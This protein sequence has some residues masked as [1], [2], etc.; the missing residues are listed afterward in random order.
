MEKK[1]YIFL[2]NISPKNILLILFIL[3]AVYYFHLFWPQLNVLVTPDFGSSDIWH[4]HMPLK[5]FLAE[6]L[7]N[8]SFPF[9][10][11]DLGTGYPLLAQGH[12]G[13]FNIL[14]IVIYYCFSFPLASNLFFFINTLICL[15]GLN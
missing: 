5:Y 2:K 4:G 3:A 10:S 14:N 12:L 15:L 1:K 8:H 7:K 13:T 11:K 9:W 6:S